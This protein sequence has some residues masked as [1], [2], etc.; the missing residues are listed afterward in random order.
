MKVIPRPVQLGNDYAGEVW[1]CLPDSAKKLTPRPVG[2]I[3]RFKTVAT[4]EGEQEIGGEFFELLTKAL[5]RPP[6]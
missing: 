4:R 5:T 1:V 2:E 6:R 3:E